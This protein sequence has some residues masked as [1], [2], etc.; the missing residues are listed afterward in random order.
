MA[1]GG[2]NV[3]RLWVARA[4]FLLRFGVQKCSGWLTICG[5]QLRWRCHG[6]DGAGSKCARVAP[7]LFLRFLHS[8]GQ[9]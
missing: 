4:P 5:P 6:S 7:P 3:L 9:H 8:G 2:F 1:A